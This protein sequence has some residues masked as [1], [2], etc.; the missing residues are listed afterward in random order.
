MREYQLGL[1]MAEGSLQLLDGNRKLLTEK[2]YADW[3]RQL[4]LMRL[5]MLDRL[6]EWAEYIEYF[7]GLSALHDDRYISLGYFAGNE[8]EVHRPYIMRR[9][10]EGFYVHFLYFADYRYQIICRK[11]AR[12]QQGRPVEHQKRHQRDRLTDEELIRRADEYFERYDIDMR[13][14]Q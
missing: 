5:E 2:E 8:S 12:Q 9:E 3:T 10:K 13:D 7:E 6:N 1:E 11:Y 4:M 14:P